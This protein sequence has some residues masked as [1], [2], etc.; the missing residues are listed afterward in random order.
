MT[1]V[2]VPDVSMALMMTTTFTLMR[3]MTMTMVMVMMMMMMMINC[4]GTLSLQ[5]HNPFLAPGITIVR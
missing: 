2:M 1:G 3:M 5:S 4:S